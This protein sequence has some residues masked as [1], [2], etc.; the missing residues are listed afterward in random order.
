MP[1]SI[2]H[3]HLRSPD[4]DAS[5]AFYV[6]MFDATITARTEDGARL[7]VSLS[8]GGLPTFIDRVPPETAAPPAP[9][10]LGLEH[11]GLRVPD[12]DESAAAL[13]AKGAEFTLEPTEIRPGIKIAFVQAPDGVRVEILERAG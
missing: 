10:F 7:R 1:Y 13:R 11:I 12:L 2:D 6:A 5:A 9:P 8:L 4:P 3:I